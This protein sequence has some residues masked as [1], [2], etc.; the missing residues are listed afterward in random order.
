M[1]IDRSEPGVL[2]VVCD[3]CGERHMLELGD[4]ATN[5]EIAE[6]LHLMSWEHRPPERVK[7]NDGLS[8]PIIGIFEQD[9][10]DDCT[11][12]TPDPKPRYCKPRI[13]PGPREND[14]CDEWDRALIFDAV[15]LQGCGHPHGSRSKCVYCDMGYPVGETRPFWK[16]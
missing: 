7:F 6:E 8:K 9:F 13:A 15:G 5:D 2:T 4:D 1:T 12:G 16:R 11:D 10:C 14:P 3:H